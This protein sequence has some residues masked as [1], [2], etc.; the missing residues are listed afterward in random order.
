MGRTH[1]SYQR[2]QPADHWSCRGHTLPESTCCHPPE[3]T[4]QPTPPPPLPTCY[5][6]NLIMH[7]QSQKGKTTEHTAG[8]L[9]HHHHNHHQVPA[10]EEHISRGIT[11]YSL[12]DWC[13]RLGCPPCKGSSAPW[14]GHPGRQ[15]PSRSPPAHSSAGVAGGV[16]VGSVMGGLGT[17]SGWGMLRNCLFQDW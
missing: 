14:L 2:N 17:Q 15:C 5:P 8:S 9:D 1:K 10:S 13:P 4:S 16:V 7:Q 12:P 3:G 6:N 11:T